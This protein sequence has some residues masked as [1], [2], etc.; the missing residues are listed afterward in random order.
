MPVTLRRPINGAAGIRDR[1]NRKSLD[2]FAIRPLAIITQ[3]LFV[4]CLLTYCTRLLIKPKYALN[5]TNQ[6][7]KERKKE[8]KE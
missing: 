4:L 3:M 8:R 7:K 5:K 6:K 1:S 2:N